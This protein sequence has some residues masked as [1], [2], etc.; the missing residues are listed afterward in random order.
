MGGGRH[1]R[2]ARARGRPA[3]GD[4]D[5]PPGLRRLRAARAGDGE[6]DVI[7]APASRSWCP[8]A[9]PAWAIRRREDRGPRPR[10]RGLRGRRS[11][12]PARRPGV[13]ARG[14]GGRA[15]PRRPAR[16]VRAARRDL[17]RPPAGGSRCSTGRSTSTR[18]GHEGRRARGGPGP[19][20]RPVRLVVPLLN[21]VDHLAPARALSRGGR[22]DDPHHRRPHRP[23]R[24]RADLAPGPGG[25]RDGGPAPTRRPSRPSSRARGS[26]VCTGGTEARVMWSKLVPERRWPARRPPP[27][28]RSA[29]S[30]RT[31]CGARAWTARSP[32]AA[33]AGAGASVDP[34]ATRASSTPCRPARPRPC[35]ATRAGR[36]TELDAIAG[37]VL[38]AGQ[39]HG[40]PTPETAALAELVA[41]GLPPPA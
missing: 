11:S 2:R 9:H 21:G 5:V 1:D 36:P 33:V 22:R 7:T 16:L 28:S 35:S 32:R 13:L 18:G 31:P 23:R 41:R 30:A 24:D 25:S 39:R 26:P 38:R 8:P 29:R 40:L 6:T 12:G 15:R 3:R 14:D 10:G 20:P 34:V 27:I 19:R 37:A 4:G 17:D